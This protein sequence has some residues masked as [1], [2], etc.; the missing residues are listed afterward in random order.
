MNGPRLLLQAALITAGFAVA[1]GVILY[2][3]TEPTWTFVHRWVLMAVGVGS[4]DVRMLH[5]IGTGWVGVS[6]G[7]QGLSY[8]LISYQ[9][10]AISFQQN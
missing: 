4:G 3:G 9:L 2:L 1:D 6:I 5:E 8:H 10:S 7:H